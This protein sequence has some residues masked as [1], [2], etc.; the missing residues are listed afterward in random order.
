[1]AGA[2]ATASLSCELTYSSY[3]LSFTAAEISVKGIALSW[4]TTKNSTIV[5]RSDTYSL[6][7]GKKV[8]LDEEFA[9]VKYEVKKFRFTV[10]IARAWKN[11][12]LVK[13]LMA[14]KC[15]E[16]TIKAIF[17]GSEVVL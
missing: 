15:D 5:L 3:S 2:G 13:Q 12:T 1:H 11:I 16:N 8:F 6:I 14:L 17:E 9:C 10:G 7:E 4:E